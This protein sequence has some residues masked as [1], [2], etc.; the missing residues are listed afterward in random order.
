MA[1]CAI[2]VQLRSF[3]P[4]FA[5]SGIN[6][7]S[8]CCIALSL[9]RR[10]VGIEPLIYFSGFLHP[11]VM[12]PISRLFYYLLVSSRR[13]SACLSWRFAVCDFSDYAAFLHGDCHIALSLPN[14][15]KRRLFERAI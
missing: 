9:S 2:N 1:F 5:Q 14:L 13:F 7:I 8:F 11:M 10:V 12:M 15:V 6:F 3:N 4:T